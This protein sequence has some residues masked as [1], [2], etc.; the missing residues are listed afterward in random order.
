[1]T[2]LEQALRELAAATR[3]PE[4]PELA[5]RVVAAIGASRR[6]RRRRLVAALAIA[7]LV[8][9]GVAFA[10]APARSAILD[11]LGFGGAVE[12]ERVPTLPTVPRIRLPLGRATTLAGAER[13]TGFRPRVLPGH[14][15]G[16]YVQGEG[17]TLVYGGILLGEV[18][19]RGVIVA[20]KV[21][22]PGTTVEDVRVAG[23]PGLWLS[24]EPHLFA[25]LDPRG[26]V[27]EGRLRL[28]GNTLLWERGGL[29]LRLEGTKTKA[30]ALRLAR[31]V[32]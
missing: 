16:V 24:G 28:A 12:V 5:G 20:R 29:V 8:A 6:R 11:W 19:G 27:V 2:D 13:A 22:G 31:S 21:V 26:R 32:R 1:M 18:R 25:Y 7:A 15:D 10:V 23:A 17:I 14:L 4:T 30:A 9:T 3:F